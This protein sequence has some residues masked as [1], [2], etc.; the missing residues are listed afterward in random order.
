MDE[1]SDTREEQPHLE[2]M[3]AFT[4]AMQVSRGVNNITKLF[5][6][7][8]LTSNIITSPR[9][10]FL[11]S[12]PALHCAFIHITLKRHDLMEF[13]DDP[14]HW[15]KN[16]VKVGRSWRKDELRL[17][18]NSDLHKLWFVLLKERNML[19]TM[20]EA[21]KEANE[22]FPNPERLDKVEDSM[23]NLEMVVCERNRAY[24]MLETGETGE[25]PGKLVYSRLGIRFF[26]RMRQY[27]FP[28]FMNKRWFKLHMHGFNGIGTR[29]FLRFYREKLWL[30]KR[31]TRNRERNRV[32]M[33][34]RKF[35]NLDLKAVEQEYPNVDIEAVKA[36][37]KARG[38]YLPK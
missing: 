9:H 26:Y 10:V 2:K 31:K 30:E 29:K 3:A 28:K 18:S 21:S 38:H 15:A 37:K 22:V 25:R 27:S 32:T 36:S 13:F 12:T 8:S 20:E 33:L 11:R 4:K 14:K 5:T 7:L 6:N 19:M 35:P 1:D 24:H 17:K 34:I 23:N 16:E